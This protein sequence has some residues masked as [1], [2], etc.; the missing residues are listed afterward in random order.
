MVTAQ[1]LSV[2]GFLISIA[3]WWITWIAGLACMILLLCAACCRVA[4]APLLISAVLGVV[5]AIGQIF[6]VV[7]AADFLI[8]CMNDA[9]SDTNVDK[10]CKESFIRTLG[11]VG[12]LL[13]T[14]VVILTS[15]FVFTRFDKYES[16]GG[17]GM[18]GPTSTI[19]LPNYYA[20]DQPNQQRD[21]RTTTISYLQDG[22]MQTETKI[23]NPDGSITVE[24]TT[25]SPSN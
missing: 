21:G 14:F 5:V 8:M 19:A 4:K 20:Q 25:Q 6:V 23:Y 11:I 13:W 1:V 24:V 16:G 10:Y 2:L 18:T 22:S 15:I 7:N 9:H 12:I 3:G 17:M